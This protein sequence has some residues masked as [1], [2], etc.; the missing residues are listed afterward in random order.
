MRMLHLFVTVLLA[1]CGGLM[2]ADKPPRRIYAHYM[3]CYPA[4]TAATAH[5]RSRV[6]RIRHDA[7]D[8]NASLGGRIRHWPL[9]PEST[10]LGLKESA[11]LEIQR[12]VRIGLDGFAVDAWA[13]GDGARQMLSA[14]FG[15]AEETD[16]PFRLTICL[17][18]NC[19]KPSGDDG[20]VGAY[21]ETLRW[22]LENHGNSP[23]LARREGK[24]L[25]FG[26]HSRGLGRGQRPRDALK[27][28]GA[29]DELAGLYAELERRIGRSFYFHFGMGA[30]FHGV[31]LRELEGARPP[32]Q[33]GPWMVRA[34]ARMAE[35]F[36]AVGAF[37]DRDFY[38]ELPQMARAVRAAGAEWCQPL[39]HQYQNQT[40]M[41]MVEPGTEILRDRWRLARESG[42]TLLQYVTWN[43]YG[44][45]TNLAPDYR[46]RYAIYD[47]NAYFIRW[48]K[49]GSP[50]PVERDRL[51]L[52]YRNYPKGA[53]TFPFRSR[54]FSEGQL[55]VI[56]LLAEPAKIVIPG[57][58]AGY[59]AP[60]G[61]H[62]EQFALK[63]GEVT[64]EVRRDGEQV[65][66]I[67]A[68]E[69]ITERPFREDNSMVAFS[70]E[71]RRHW[72]ADF[73]D[74]PPFTAGTYGD[75][76][77]DG[78]PNWFEMYW[79]G[80]FQDWSTATVADPAAD[81]DED[82][83]SNLEEWRAQTDPTEPPPLY[84]VGDVWDLST[85][86]EKR[87]S[88]NPD[89]DFNGTPVWYYLYRIG[90]KPVP[91]DGR[92][93]PCPHNAQDTPYTGI[94]MHSSPYRAEGFTNVHG[95]IDRQEQ[96]DGSLQ[97]RIRS[98]RQVDLIL[99]WKS[100]IDGTVSLRVRPG[101]TRERPVDLTVQH[102]RPLR[103]LATWRVTPDEAEPHRLSEI[104]VRRGDFLYL[105]ASQPKNAWGSAV[106]LRD[107]EIRAESVEEPR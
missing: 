24:P 18:P 11:R 63:A 3:G 71:F 62:V 100:P 72:K 16:A 75:A 25:I 86:H 13:G 35:H 95:W 53:G 87:T 15:V 52:I 1:G 41:L 82:G 66:R 42:S 55:E 26:Y 77:G 33:P 54:R 103:E 69:P 76:D 23:K 80:K 68:P 81:P 17:D 65:L 102:S 92:Y 79:F 36:P 93:R 29:W 21:E 78:L 70:S 88:F 94:M 83:R 9:V 84:E 90:R 5:H 74:A 60:A 105:V 2:G 47:L 44:E 40:A 49:E 7:A 38:R 10:H 99:G 12:A 51:Y 67:T 104:D 96:S 64:A 56:S 58:H 34:A 4:A 98:R 14:L 85:V 6:H 106:V 31:D 59:R 22:L 50:P 20:L 45:A 89:P 39:W 27:D 19:H 37:L 28:P 43:D 30:F 61:L 91:L 48:W 32:H 8:R 73:G 101:I 57:R 46:N 107:L 97:V